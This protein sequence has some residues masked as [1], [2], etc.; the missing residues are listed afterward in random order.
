MA[1]SIGSTGE[2]CVPEDAP[3]LPG[4]WVGVCPA[5][6]LLERHRRPERVASCRRCADGFS[7]DH[8]L[9]WTFRGRPAQMHP[10]Y[11]AELEVL[12]R[13]T[14]V[15]RFGAGRRVRITVPGEFHGRTGVVVR[16]GRTSYH[17]RVPE[18]VLRVVF[19]GVEAA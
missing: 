10:N 15:V 16:R 19:A 3:R 6:H 18:G 1:R 12:V 4:H 9:E 11:V 5:G 7:L 8:L 14:R 17:V 13:G 2:R